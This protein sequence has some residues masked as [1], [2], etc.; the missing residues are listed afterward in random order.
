[1]EQWQQFQAMS[2]Q[3]VPSRVSILLIMT[4]Q[5]WQDALQKSRAEN[6]GQ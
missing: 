6:I 5:S 1:M 3:L 4:S 2:L